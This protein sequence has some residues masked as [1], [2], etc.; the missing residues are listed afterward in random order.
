MAGLVGVCNLLIKLYELKRDKLKDQEAKAAETHRKK[1][2]LLVTALFTLICFSIPLFTVLTPSPKEA[3]TAAHQSAA[4]ASARAQALSQTAAPT[5]STVGK[6]AEQSRPPINIVDT[7]A[8]TPRRSLS[9]LLTFIVV[10][11][12]GLAVLAVA[13]RRQRGVFI[14]NTLASSPSEQLREIQKLRNEGVI[15]ETEAGAFKSAI[16]ERMRKQYGVPSDTP[17]FASPSGSDRKAR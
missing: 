1:Q 14:S 9:T 12:A 10:T 11:I 5:Q 4:E 16:V 8:I 15:S 2:K 6:Q 7:D 17:G 3:E 13:V